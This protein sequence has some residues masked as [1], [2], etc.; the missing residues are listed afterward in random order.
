MS[1][2]LDSCRRLNVDERVECY[3]NGKTF[4]C[5]CGQ[6][7]GVE[8]DVRTVPCPSCDR[9]LVDG[10]ASEREAPDPV[11]QGGQTQLGDW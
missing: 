4:E 11:D 5:D 6:G 3:E 8:F 2:T 10:R 7:F 9:V 1:T